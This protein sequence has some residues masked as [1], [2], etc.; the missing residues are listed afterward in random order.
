[1]KIFITVGTTKFDA[2]IKYI[3]TA[4]C[5]RNFDIEFQ[6]ADGKYAPRNHPYITFV[7]SGAVN[8]K[9][10]EAD[11]IITHAGQGTIFKLLRMGKKVIVVPNLERT[12]KH[13]LDI[14]GYVQKNN[15]ALVALNLAQLESLLDTIRDREFAKFD[16]VDFFKANEI[17]EYIL[18]GA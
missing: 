1:M 10:Q 4:P 15:Y 9:Y 16:A 2:L 12:D 14:A 3:D 7:D 5:F 11:V 18:T 17:I 13:Q 8:N 6:I